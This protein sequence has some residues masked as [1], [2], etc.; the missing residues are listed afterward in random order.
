MKLGRKSVAAFVF[1]DPSGYGTE[2]ALKKWVQ[3]G[4]DFVSSLPPKKRSAT[5]PKSGGV[6]NRPKTLAAR[7]GRTSKLP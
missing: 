2:T 7:D 3:R 4:L 1:V 5:M 6:T